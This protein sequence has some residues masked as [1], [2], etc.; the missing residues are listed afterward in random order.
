MDLCEG[1]RQLSA[2]IQ[3]E[4]GLP[5]STYRSI[6][7]PVWDGHLSRTGMGADRDQAGSS[8]KDE[9]NS[10]LLTEAQRQ[11]S[12]RGKGGRRWLRGTRRNLLFH[13]DRPQDSMN[14]C[15]CW[16]E[17][18][19]YSFYQSRKP[20]CVVEHFNLG[21]A[22][23]P[24]SVDIRFPPDLPAAA[25]NP[26]LSSLLYLRRFCVVGASIEWIALD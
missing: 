25:P 13:M 12:R 26:L 7:I 6:T 10:G 24:R 15:E 2:H 4:R 3:R 23:C 11:R 20:P 18:I 5:S 1:I 16:S 8:G 9:G 21:L 19:V 22:F 17:S 14:T